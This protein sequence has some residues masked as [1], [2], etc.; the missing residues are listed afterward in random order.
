MDEAFRNEKE[1]EN[2]WPPS[3]QIFVCILVSERDEHVEYFGTVEGGNGEQV[4]GHQSKVH[5]DG[6]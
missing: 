5:K 6:A 3:H 4:K 1:K 2:I